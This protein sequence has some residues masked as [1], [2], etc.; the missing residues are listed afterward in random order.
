MD[1]KITR[2]AN[3]GSGSV[4]MYG[5][6]WPL[7]PGTWRVDDRARLL[8]KVDDARYAP[9]GWTGGRLVRREDWA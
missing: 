3:S 1:K 8:V 4:L 7:S 2:M 9:T 5:R 6:R